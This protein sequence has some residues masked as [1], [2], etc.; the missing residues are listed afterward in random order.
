MKNIFK[1]K[2][3]ALKKSELMIDLKDPRKYGKDVQRTAAY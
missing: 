1:L 2:D 3:E